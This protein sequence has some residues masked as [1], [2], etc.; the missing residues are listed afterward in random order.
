MKAKYFVMLAFAAMMTIT[1]C[2]SN[3]SNQGGE[4]K[5]SVPEVKAEDQVPQTQVVD[6][7]A[8]DGE[9]IVFLEDDNLIRPAME[10]KKPMIIDFNATW[11]GPCQNFAPTFDEMAKKYGDVTFVS[12]DIDKNPL[13]AEAFGVQ[14]IPTVI[15]VVPGQP[16]KT[17]VGTGDL[18]PAEKFDAIV[19]TAIEDSKKL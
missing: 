5:D 4:A 8:K 2:G 1:S 10:L 18:L 12:I 9:S 16:E 11:C 17:Y 6:I 13:T 7:V 3:K 15:V 19:K 14:S